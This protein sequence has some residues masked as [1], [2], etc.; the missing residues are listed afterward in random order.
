MENDCV[1]GHDCRIIRWFELIQNGELSLPSFQ[2]KGNQWN[3]VLVKDFL[4]TIFNK[5]PGGWALV[6]SVGDKELFKS[7]PMDGAPE[8][9][10]VRFQLLDGQQRLTSLWRSFNNDFANCLYVVRFDDNCEF[11]GVEYYNK[12]SHITKLINDP[13]QCLK[14][15]C[16]P[17]HILHPL[18]DN[19]DMFLDTILDAVDDKLLYRKI[20]NLIKSL[21]TRVREFNIP[22][23]ELP[24]YITRE[25]AYN[26]FIKINTN[27][28]KLSTYDMV[29]VFIE[30][31]AADTG[32]GAFDFRQ[33]TKELMNSINGLSSFISTIKGLEKVLL[34][35]ISMRQGVEPADSHFLLREHEQAINYAKVVEEWDIIRRN[36]QDVL[37]FIADQGILDSKLMFPTTIFGV[38]VSLWDTIPRN[39]DA[40]GKILSLLRKYVW[41]SYFTNRYNNTVAKRAFEDLCGLLHYI[42]GEQGIQQIPIFNDDIYPLCNEQD[43]I[44]TSNKQLLGKGIMALCIRAGAMDI[45]TGKKCSC[46]M[47]NQYEYHHIFPKSMLAE[48][49][50]DNNEIINR[51]LNFMLLDWE[52][53]RVFGDNAPSVYLAARIKNGDLQPSVVNS[54]IASHLLPG[55]FLEYCDYSGMTNETRLG[56]IVSDYKVFLQLRAAIILKAIRTVTDDESLV[57]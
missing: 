57:F 38:L 19:D 7:R 33:N 41:R 53:N 30:E 12:N 1:V 36:M 9:T 43:I 5:L 24:A 49:F 16:I 21:K 39:A 11:L 48:S 37:Y 13:M 46:G 3:K 17:L 6:L 25:I 27:S 47:G 26:T 23:L 45:I 44:Y 20:D 56:R 18:K 10:K 42:R 51:A 32:A 22:Y 8:L 52:T 54:R 15:H 14:E 40:Q 34:F 35:I 2:R 29:N 31:D 28:I 50:G 55:N 4:E